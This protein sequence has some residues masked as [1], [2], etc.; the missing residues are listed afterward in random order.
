M[1]DTANIGYENDKRWSKLHFNFPKPICLTF[2]IIINIDYL[3]T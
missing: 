2:L 1:P 3:D